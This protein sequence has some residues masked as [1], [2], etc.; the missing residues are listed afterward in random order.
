MNNHRIHVHC[1]LVL[2]IQIKIALSVPS[3]FNTKKNHFTTPF[4]FISITQNSIFASVILVE[5]LFTSWISVVNCTPIGQLNAWFLLASFM[6]DSYWSALCLIP[7]GQFYA[8]F[9]L[10][11]FMFPTSTQALPDWFLRWRQLKLQF[12]WTLENNISLVI[13]KWQKYTC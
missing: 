5:D 12:L 3:L 4:K 6:L 8:C 1:A 9:L 13:V 7:I 11:S 10:V 2:N